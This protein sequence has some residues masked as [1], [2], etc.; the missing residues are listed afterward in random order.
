MAPPLSAGA[1]L[2]V[3]FRCGRIR[4]EGGKG[5]PDPRKGLLR[6]LRVRPC[7]VRVALGVQRPLLPLPACL[8]LRAL[9]TSTSAAAATTRVLHVPLTRRRRTACCTCSSGRARSTAPAS[10]SLTRLSSQRRPCLSRCVLCARGQSVRRREG[11]AHPQ[12]GA[13]Q[14]LLATGVL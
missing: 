6:L 10:P 7:V 11:G 5:T 14:H 9:T 8:C 1:K 4:M 3:E 13:T 12:A 2:L